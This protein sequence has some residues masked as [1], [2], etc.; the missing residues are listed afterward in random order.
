MKQLK[1][2]YWISLCLPNDSCFLRFYLAQTHPR[3]KVRIQ[4][5]KDVLEQTSD[6]S[7]TQIVSLFLLTKFLRMMSNFYSHCCSAMTLQ[8]ITMEFDQK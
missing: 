1:T 8:L 4:W 5:S 6:A 2:Q 3:T 7:L